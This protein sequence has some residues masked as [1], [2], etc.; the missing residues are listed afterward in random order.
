M[1]FQHKYG[2]KNRKQSFKPIQFQIMKQFLAYTIILLALM[3]GGCKR[4]AGNYPGGQVSSYIALFDVRNMYKGQDVT[5]TKENMFGA[6]TIA[7]V[8]T[9][10]YS[11]SNIPA[12]LI[13]I[14]DRRRLNQL[15]GIA[16][17]VDDANTY[18]PGDSV[19]VNVEGAVLKRV[20]GILQITGLNKA[21]I[22]KVATGRPVAP[23]SVKANAILGTPD[24]FE[25]V[26]V[27]LTR[28]GFDPGI[29]PGSTYAGDR[30]INDGFG[31]L[32]LHTET[33]ATF[34][35]RPLPFLANFTGLVFQSPDGTPNLWP[36]VDADITILSATAPKIAPIVISG[37]LM[38]P[39]GTDAN[40]EY[41]QL[42]ATRDI[43][44]A[45]TP[46]SVV[47]T[48]NAGTSTPTGFPTDG[49]ATGGLR[50]YKFNLTSG[51]VPKGQYFY[52]GAN[53]NINGLGSTDIS[54]ARWFGKMYSTVNGD[55]FGTLTANLLA[56]SGNAAGIAVFDRIN[57][58][59]T[60][61]PVDV[62]FYGGAGSVYTPGPPERG[63]RIT[64]T[65]YYDEKNPNTQAD[66]P[67]FN[68]GSNTG[69]FSFP[70]VTSFAR[71]GGKYNRTSGR[72]VNARILSNVLLTTTTPLSGIE[73]GGTTIEE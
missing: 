13:T 53:K 33:S 23:L 7:G 39:A 38:D 57:V 69:K 1:L 60:T 66:Q 63:Y 56:N 50:T 22:T 67:F 9:S 36:R 45:V 70:T 28:V 44:F 29:P 11:G 58:D 16:I 21:R 49:W 46:F 31:N 61:V 30:L 32:N 19:Q 41:I 35:N 48:N 24:A 15:R 27:S 54:S 47:T 43:D 37:F 42:L 59:A 72:W 10:D 18:V 4:D 55:G 3:A 20:N 25:S 51:T 65:D 14:Q 52:V 6:T 34:A 5:L 40:Y 8:V 64:N 71:L 26:L 12:G 2:G 17:P 73:T 62:I 68:Q